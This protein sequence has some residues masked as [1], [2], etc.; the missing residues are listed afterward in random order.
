MERKFV[1]T[2]D[3]PCGSG[4]TTAAKTVAEKLGAMYLDTGA[5]YRAAKNFHN[6]KPCSGKNTFGARAFVY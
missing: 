2:I 3:G 4:K 5:L 1:I 6:S